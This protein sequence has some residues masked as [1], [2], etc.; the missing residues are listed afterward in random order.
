MLTHTKVILATGC[1]A[2]VFGSGIP[3]AAIAGDD[4]AVS[5]NLREFKD[6]LRWR[7]SSN[8]SVVRKPVRSLKSSSSISVARSCMKW[9]CVTNPGKSGN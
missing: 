3:G 4:D 8:A 6:I 1:T 2:F 7:R 9:S 5:R